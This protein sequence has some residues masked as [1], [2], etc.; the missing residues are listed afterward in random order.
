MSGMSDGVA[1]IGRIK[2]GCGSLTVLL[3]G[4]AELFTCRNTMLRAALGEERSA[5]EDESGRLICTKCH[6]E[7]TAATRK[8]READGESA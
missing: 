6:Q 3:R 2:C 7:I 1:W 5:T 8:E 4:P